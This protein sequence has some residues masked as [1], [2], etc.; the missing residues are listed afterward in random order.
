[1]IVDHHRRQPTT[2]LTCFESVG[3]GFGRPRCD[4]PRSATAG[5][6][7]TDSEGAHR[8]QRQRPVLLVCSPPPSQHCCCFVD[9]G[10]T[11]S[12]LQRFASSAHPAAASFAPVAMTGAGAGAAAFMAEAAAAVVEAAAAAEAEAG[13]CC[14]WR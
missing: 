1:M 13:C 3:D 2:S 11:G 10:L 7:G 8:H 14:C 9:G 5:A 6:A 12:A 4:Y